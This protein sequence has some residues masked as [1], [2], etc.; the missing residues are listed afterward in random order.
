M[1]HT[2]RSI[3]YRKVLN[4]F[5]FLATIDQKLM[6]LRES[7][8]KHIGIIIVYL[9]FETGELVKGVLCKDSS[10]TIC[11]T[12]IVR[13]DIVSVKLITDASVI[14]CLRLHALKARNFVNITGLFCVPFRY[15]A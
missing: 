13:H 4:V 15:F 5:N 6:V 11:A 10:L 8:V 14:Y 2:N 1:S 7:I 12:F 9:I 3:N